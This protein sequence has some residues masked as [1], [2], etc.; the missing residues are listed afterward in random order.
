MHG[1]IIQNWACGL[2]SGEMEGRGC[3]VT[4]NETYDLHKATFLNLSSLPA[5]C[6]SMAT[7]RIGAGNN[8]RIS[9]HQ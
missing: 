5:S 2:L 9:P 6:L 8:C 3:R 7:V 4:I 1:I